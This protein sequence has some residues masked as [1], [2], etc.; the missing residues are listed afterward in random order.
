M[1]KKRE[2][3]IGAHQDDIFLGAGI[4]I[5]KDPSNTQILVLT[6]GSSAVKYPWKINGQTFNSPEEYFA[7]RTKEDKNLF[8]SLG[9]DV[10][11]KYYNASFPDGGLHK[12][13]PNAIKYLEKMVETH[14]IEIILTHSV[15]EAHP[16]HEV[17]WF[18]SNQVAK[19]RGIEFWEF[20]TYR[21]DQEG[22]YFRGFPEEDLMEEIKKF[23]LTEEEIKLKKELSGHYKTQKKIVDKFNFPLEILGKRKKFNPKTIPE[24]EYY[25]GKREGHP[26]CLEIRALMENQN[27]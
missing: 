13:I 24:T 21:L 16:D 22:N 20:A 6:D 17:A 14:K 5:S 1:P 10:A 7:Q 18:I 3:Y 9:I 12:N 2:L 25:Y 15:P 8:S 27:E 19:K 26:S 11:T 23:P 4:Q